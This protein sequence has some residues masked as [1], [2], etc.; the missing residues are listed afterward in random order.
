MFSEGHRPFVRS[1]VPLFQTESK[2]ETILMKMICVKMRLHAEL[3]FIW[4]VSHLDSFSH[5]STRELR[6]GL[7]GVLSLHYLIQVWRYATSG[8]W[9]YC[10]FFQM[11]CSHQAGEFALAP[12]ARAVSLVLTVWFSQLLKVFSLVSANNVRREIWRIS[13]NAQQEQ[14]SV[15]DFQ[16]RNG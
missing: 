4:K 14:W 2:C 11:E 3:I 8:W 16:E 1:L 15:F 5:G 13:E 10:R 12:P 9:E 7:F 6:N